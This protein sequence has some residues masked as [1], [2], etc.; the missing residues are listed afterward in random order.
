MDFML[1]EDKPETEVVAVALIVRD[2][3]VV[4]FIFMFLLFKDGSS[5]VAAFYGVY[6]KEGIK[7]C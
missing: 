1:F 2:G 3:C 4:K 7:K 6:A 5:V